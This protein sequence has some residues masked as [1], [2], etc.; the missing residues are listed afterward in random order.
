MRRFSRA[1]REG[2]SAHERVSRGAPTRHIQRVSA[3]SCSATAPTGTCLV[4][5]RRGRA[6]LAARGCPPGGDARRR[7][8]FAM[9]CTSRHDIKVRPGRGRGDMGAGGG[10][11]A[12]TDWSCRQMGA[13]KLS[14]GCHMGSRVE[15]DMTAPTPPRPAHSRARRHAP[16]HATRM[17]RPCARQSASAAPGP[18]MTRVYSSE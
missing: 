13:G 14:R 7:R 18:A 8:S 6:L 2:A 3:H 1:G 4:L 15:R 17:V 11:L 9:Q 12:A 16:R 10:G 5:G